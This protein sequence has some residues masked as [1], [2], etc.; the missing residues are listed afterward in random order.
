MAKIRGFVLV[1]NELNLE[2]VMKQVS[3]K[4]GD[5]LSYIIHNCES[6]EGLQK[7]FSF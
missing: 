7:L 6:N 5:F 2:T 3:T 1:F 4:Q